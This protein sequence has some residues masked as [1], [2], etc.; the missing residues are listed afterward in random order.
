MELFETTGCLDEEQ[1]HALTKVET[2]YGEDGLHLLKRIM[3]GNIGAL[4]LKEI[5]QISEPVR[6]VIV[7]LP[8]THASSLLKV[9]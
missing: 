3:A 2:A 8:D 1:R 5:A 9:A 6:A 4:G 7:L